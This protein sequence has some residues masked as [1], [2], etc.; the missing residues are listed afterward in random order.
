MLIID[1]QLLLPP[2]HLHP[3]LMHGLRNRSTNNNITDMKKANQFSLL[4]NNNNKNNARFMP[5]APR[6]NVCI[7]I[8]KRHIRRYIDTRV[9]DCTNREIE[10]LNACRWQLDQTR[11]GSGQWQRHKRYRHY[12]FVITI[13]CALLK[14]VFIHPDTFNRVIVFYLY[15]FGCLFLRFTNVIGALMRIYMF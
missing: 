15:F 9:Y 2:C 5:Y 6:A 1:S 12:I 4:N 7:N 14:G 10:L 13:K 8:D 3:L 11:L